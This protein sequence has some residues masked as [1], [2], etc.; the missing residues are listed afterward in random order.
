MLF[1]VLELFDKGR[2]KDRCSAADASIELSKR[3]ET[4]KLVLKYLA[5]RKLSACPG[6]TLPLPSGL[7]ILSIDST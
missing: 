6:L 7:D 2:V 5:V 3:S 4:F 1:R